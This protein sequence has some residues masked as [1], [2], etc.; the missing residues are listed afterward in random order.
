MNLPEI[1]LLNYFNQVLISLSDLC[2]NDESCTL[3]SLV[4]QCESIAMG[5]QV[6]DY[7]EVLT[8]CNNGG[9]IQV[10][11]ELVCVSLLG[12]KFLDSNRERFFELTDAQKNL[13]AERMIFKG[14]WNTYARNLFKI[15]NPNFNT[16]TYECSILDSPFPIEFNATIHLF[17]FLGILRIED[18]LIIV[19]K[20]Y[21]ELVYQLTAD[22]KAISEHQLEKI[23]MENRK[24]GTKAENAVVEFEKQRLRKLGKFAHAELVKRISVLN[25]SAGYD[26]ES[27]DGN[28][29]TF[30]PNRFIE[31]KATQSDEIRFYWTSNELKVAKHKRGSYWIYMMKKFNEQ[32]PTENIP[33]MIQDPSQKIEKNN[34][35]TMQAH[36]FLIKEASDVILSERYLEEIKWYEII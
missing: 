21:S 12:K 19:E 11:K 26:I 31:V 6:V 10:K 3:K 24:L 34:Y 16:E 25:V 17:K 2:P 28:S 32:L 5:G 15:F 27:F 29:D 4:S 13:M 18:P 30:E 1:G 7:N 20:K 33:I 14:S 36:T 22:G 9:L 8:H 23:L 35:L